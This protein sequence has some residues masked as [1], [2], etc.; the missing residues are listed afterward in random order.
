MIKV[1]AGLIFRR[2][3]ILI[4]QRNKNSAYPL[5]WEFPGGKIEKNETSKETLQR[6][7][8]E[9]LSIKVEVGKKFFSQKWNYKNSGSFSVDFFII[10]NINGK[11]KNNIFNQIKWVKI[12]ELKRYNHL[13]GN[14]DVIEKI[15]ERFRI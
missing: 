15:R 9:E 13:E 12:F 2:N 6:E 1:V 4:C 5:K 10:E 11:I 7:L 8:F 14:A 3:K